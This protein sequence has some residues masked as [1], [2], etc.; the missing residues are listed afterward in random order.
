MANLDASR[1]LQQSMIDQA[2]ADI[3]ATAA[4]LVRARYDFDRY[5][6]LSND[7]FAPLRRFQQ[8]LAADRKARAAMEAAKRRLDVIDTQKE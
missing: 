1:R 7:R 8:A 4:E 2:E 6:T 5:R 3:A